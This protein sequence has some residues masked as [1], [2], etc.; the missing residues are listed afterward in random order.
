MTGLRIS[1]LSK[2]AILHIEEL[3]PQG[4]VHSFHFISAILLSSIFIAY[5][6]YKFKTLLENLS[7]PPEKSACTAGYHKIVTRLGVACM[8]LM[9]VSGWGLFIGSSNSAI[10][11]QIHFFGAT[12]V[13]LYI[14]MHAGVYLAT[15]G[16]QVAGQVLPKVTS[17]YKP[18]V[19]TSLGVTVILFTTWILI[20]NES[21]FNLAI[22]KISANT[23][24]EIDGFP[25]ESAWKLAHPIKIH[26]DGGANFYNGKSTVNIQALHNGLEVYMHIAWEDPTESL[27]HLPLEKI[28]KGWKIQQQGFHSFNETKYYEDKFAILISNSCDY[29]AAGTSHL[30]RKPLSNMPAN[31]HG[32]GYHY[33]TS[34]KRHD[35]WHWKAVR[36]N[37][38]YLADDSYIGNPDKVRPGARRYTAG[39]LQDGKES[40]AYLMNWAW[41][42]P[43]V[44][45][46]KRIP[47]NQR[48]ASAI[49]QADVNPDWTIPWFD[50]Q[51]YSE[52]S[53]IY[54]LGTLMPSV[55]Y[56]SNRFEGDRADVRAHAVWQDGIWSMEMVRKLNTN[57]PLDVA[58]KDGVCIWVSAFD[59][60][61]VAHTR[62][63]R[64]I[65]LEL[66]N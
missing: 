58:I 29:G 41:Y 23:V 11:R 4:Q 10:F 5:F 55:L 38:M 52:N 53:D 64:A 62:H 27:K 16:I 17:G 42:S 25:R 8:G 46:P 47:K 43:E 21:Y 26:T 9:L 15:H 57:S 28:E 24:I 18:T 12:G 2:P 40:G 50:Y 1:T 51:P 31:W 66:T 33:S 59:H 44:I 30:G 19:I 61:Q 45:T 14:F 20:H 48:S 22:N 3:L 13:F 34:S 60:S 63:S 36:T 6:I 49:Q 35:L 39:Y 56:T 37:Q 65:K 32:K 7:N 54:P